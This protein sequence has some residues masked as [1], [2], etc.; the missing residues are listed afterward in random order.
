MANDYSPFRH[1][2][3]FAGWAAAR[4]AQRRWIKTRGILEALENSGLPEFLREPAKWPDEPV[5]FDELHRGW[6]RR[7]VANVRSH[8]DAE[9]TFGR[10]AK[11]VAVYL[12]SMVV[13]GPDCDSVLARI[14]HPPI[15]R[16][17][18]QGIAK[19]RRLDRAIRSL[20]RTCKWT[21]LTEDGYYELITELRRRNMHRPAFWR[22]ERYWNVAPDTD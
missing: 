10:A 7:I 21:E 16:F 15:D 19:D 20:C 5:D 22:L 9:A 14:A 18:L 2:H 17:V 13:V 12:K 11:V 8:R 3:N 6:C 4:A 1:R